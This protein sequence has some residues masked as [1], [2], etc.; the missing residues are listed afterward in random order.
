MFNEMSI[1]FKPD[2]MEKRLA[3]KQ[4]RVKVLDEIADKVGPIEGTRIDPNDKY[5]Q[6]D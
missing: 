4:E 5:L 1:A 2:A 6:G 3:R